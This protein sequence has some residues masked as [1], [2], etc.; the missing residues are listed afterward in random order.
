[1][2][3]PTSI[4]FFAPIAALIITQAKAILDINTNGM[5][6]VWEKQY[7]QG[8]LLP[9]TILSTSD[10]DLDG[11]NNLTESIAGTNPFDPNQPTGIVIPQIQPNPAQGFFHI[12]HPSI[13][14]KTYLLQGS[15]DLLSW[16]DIN[17]VVLAHETQLS[18]V[19]GL[20]TTT[21]QPP[22]AFFW[23][24]QIG[25]YDSD[26]DDLTDAEEHILQTNPYHN[27]SD[28]DGIHDKAE[29]LRALD[30]LNYDTDADALYDGLEDTLTTNPN[31]PDTDS[32]GIPDGEEIAN[33]TNPLL[34]D[35]DGDGLS[36]LTEKNLRTNPLLAD[37]D[38]D[39]TPDGQEITNSTNPLSNDTDQDGIPDGADTTPLAN[40][41]LADPD[42]ANLPSNLTTVDTNNLRARWDFN[43]YA[44]AASVG[45]FPP[46]ATTAVGNI[47]VANTGASFDGPDDIGR[48]VHGMP[49]SCLHFL[50]NG[51][52]A[53]MPPATYLH[54]LVGQTWSMWIQFTPGALHQTSGIRTWF[55]YG[56]NA[57]SSNSSSNPIL[58]TYFHNGTNPTLKVDGY[59]ASGG[60]GE[61]SRFVTINVP[62]HL[63]DGNWHHISFTRAYISNASRYTLTVDG[64]PTSVSGGNNIN[65]APLNT[66]PWARIGKFK[67]I[68]TLNPLTL[69]L[70]YTDSDIQ[71]SARI[72]RLR[73]YGR[74]L[75]DAENLALYNQDID[76]DNI[77]D[78]HEA[79]YRLWRDHNN[80][81]LR[82]PGELYHI[83]RPCHYDHPDADHDGDGIPTVIEITTT[84]TDPARADSDG[85][86]IPDGW[87][88]QHNLNPLNPADAN[89]DPDSDGLTNINEYRHNSSPTNP[90]TDGDATNDGPEAKGPD[91]NLDT[92]DGSNPN[93][94]TDNGTR[95]PAADLL[96]LNLGVGDRS[97][98]ASEDYVLHVYQ[99]QPDGTEKRIYTL[100]SGGFGQYK[101]QT[102]SLPRDKTYTFQIDWQGTTNNSTSPLSNPEGA[103][104]DY[105][106]VIEPLSGNQTHTLI[107]AYDPKTKTVD[108]TNKLLDPQDIAPSDD[109]NDNV[110]EFLTTH[111]PKRVI[112]LR[113]AILVDA[114]RDGQFSKEDEGQITEQKPWRIW[115]NDDNDWHE[116]GGND[117]SGDSS[118]KCDCGN[119]Y[120]DQERDLVDFFPLTLQI[121]DSLKI[122]PKTDYRYAITQTLPTLSD[123]NFNVAWVK[124][125]ELENYYGP[126]DKHHTDIEF[127]RKV[128]KLNTE[129]VLDFLNG[130]VIPDDMLDRLAQGKGALLVEGRNATEHPLKLE[131]RKK[132]GNTLVSSVSLPIRISKVEDMYRTVNLMYAATEYDGTPRNRDAEGTFTRIT[133]PPAY[134]DSETNAK[135]FVFVHGFNVS[136]KKS[137]GWNAEVFKRM[138]QLGS[139]ARFVGITWDSDELLPNYHRAVFQAFQT[140]DVLG[141]A[142]SSFTGNAD[143]TIAAHSLGNMVVSHAIQDGGF[144]PS[145]YYSI[146]AAVARE[147]YTTTGIDNV[148]KRRMVESSW[149]SY[150]DYNPNNLADPPLKHLLA[151]NW[152]ELLPTEDN[153]S[154]L[155]WKNRFQDV[156][157]NT[158][159]YNFY[160]AGDDVVRDADPNR[161]TASVLA[162]ALSGHGFSSYSWAAQEYVKGGTSAALF[163]MQPSGLTQG[164]WATNI[165]HMNFEMTGNAGHHVPSTAQQAALIDVSGLIE[166]PFF[167]KFDE[168][169]LHHPA[170]GQNSVGSNL[171]GENKVKYILLARGIPALS[172]AAATHSIP[173]TEGN[174]D[175]EGT[176]RTDSNQ[177]PTEGRGN[178]SNDI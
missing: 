158:F 167:L 7:N 59:Q 143:V 166:E 56:N 77:P 34:A 14:G 148:E 24:L 58:H 30:P 131:I 60:N 163:A 79:H 168:P 29:L 125:Y 134:P 78:R 93:N 64:I 12:H 91:G 137:R 113:A 120:I 160:S 20:S 155:S 128:S 89:L 31:N 145:R 23:R 54:N 11:W 142:L 119:H 6:D 3:A 129:Y 76:N 92:D 88:K 63:D 138:H 39:G 178:N 121:R 141:G 151:A 103:D 9:N 51:A 170:K 149:K 164:G 55:S 62:H 49:H 136:P 1:M 46:T 72:D 81:L 97:Q 75:S 52:H 162:T 105:H 82:E 37:T 174:F 36:D 102:K 68:G 126:C 107:D 177:W 100:R 32:D 41:A 25:D 35:T 108:T 115:I 156:K 83:L 70:N 144:R 124:D 84:L 50:T 5:S 169:V 67:P 127:A 73:I 117:I 38:G 66:Q 171:A 123:A 101:E 106:L 146:N 8:A 161:S 114:N 153:R 139:K 175:M 19:S 61:W 10:Q 132:D 18:S 109:N 111:E 172:F 85:D 2:K 17:D 47:D 43:T 154:K 45:L 130:R 86:L 150:W 53:I 140:G 94:P 28:N 13:L 16:L 98:S 104:F 157:E 44:T 90:N 22:S 116:T 118:L 4:R 176:M 95:P 48:T 173:D 87:E 15:A 74:A 159:H 96:T 165:T 133:E 122:L 69:G 40:N 57:N 147:A 26:T 21:G 110:T 99:L 71:L 65:N 80:N 112:L 27:D 135:Y 42:G 33:G 152:H